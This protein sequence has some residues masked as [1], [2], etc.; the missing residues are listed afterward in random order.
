MWNGTDH[1]VMEMDHM[2][3]EMYCNYTYLD[4]SHSCVELYYDGSS[5]M[6]RP[7]TDFAYCEIECNGTYYEDMD[8]IEHYWNSS[9]SSCDVMSVNE[10]FC[11]DYWHYH[12]GKYMKI[13]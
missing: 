10:T 6:E 8:C 2:Y 9:N 4:E 1:M 13:L 5:C 3:C 12:H 7:A 11:D